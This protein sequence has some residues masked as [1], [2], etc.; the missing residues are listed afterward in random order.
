MVNARPNPA[1]LIRSGLAP[2]GP[3]ST[4]ATAHRHPGAGHMAGAARRA[5]VLALGLLLAL[6]LAGCSRVTIGYNMA[7]FFIER[8]ADDYLSLS[9]AQM[10]AW[11]PQ[12]EHALARHRR[13][14]LPYL[15]AF[16]DA[17]YKDNEKGFDN[18]NV[19]CLMDQFEEIYRR[20]ARIAA[21]LAAPL[22]ADLSPRQIRR[23]EHKFREDAADAAKDEQRSKTVRELK[24]AK[25][26]TES[27]EW[28]IGSVTKKQRRIIQEVTAAMPDTTRAMHAY[29]EARRRE[30]IRLLDGHASEAKIQ[31]FLADWLVD[32]HSLPPALLQARTEMRARITDLFVRLGASLS[33]AQR[34]HLSDRL[35]GLRND[36]MD[37]Q[38]Q[39]SMA[40]VRCAGPAT[41]A[42]AR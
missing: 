31:R 4:S 7:D 11:E 10:A 38:H 42:S 9:G 24:R 28:W 16:F 19:A 5:A 6:L 18:A 34:A 25:R 39:P 17:A 26:Y 15:A 37:L 35:R 27:V 12:L 8:Y 36:F 21:R 30:L 29:T 20:N 32:F 1:T 22:L 33:P 40:A 3:L 13:D 23:L 2:R 14:E 41:A